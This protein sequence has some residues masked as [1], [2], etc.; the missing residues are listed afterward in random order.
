VPEVTTL[1]EGLE[2]TAPSGTQVIWR[3]GVPVGDTTNNGDPAAPV[4]PDPVNDPGAPETAAAIQDAVDAA[5]GAD[6]IVV[7][8]GESPYAEGRGD[9]LTPALAPSQAELIDRLEATG[10]P[11]I[12][13]VVAGRP[14]V[15]QEQLDNADA[16]L[17]ASWPG[18]EGGAAIADALF[19]KTN[20]SGRLTVSW[21]KSID[22]VP[23]FY[24]HSAGEPYDPRYPFGWGL[25]YSKFKVTGLKAPDEVERNEKVKVKVELRNKGK[26]SGE[27]VVLAFV[28]RK[29][30]PSTAP[31]RQLVAFERT[32]LRK[33]DR[34]GVKL[35][36]SVKQLAVTLPS[37]DRRVV[38]GKYR[39]KVGK[40]SQ[41]FV[42]E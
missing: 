41:T 8:V 5:S 31:V 10:K 19:G 11:V 22:Q 24:N 30:G 42:V 35:S 6:A 17:M 38:P 37:G 20:P 28:K 40:E 7:A 13:V 14:L 36:F 12:I 18:S 1:R 33:G 32:S 25:S 16:A 27:H 15:M 21:P 4:P 3:Q 29:V 26:R 39:L 2:Q 34:K 9:D 23:L